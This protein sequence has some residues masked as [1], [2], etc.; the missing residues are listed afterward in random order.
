MQW[1]PLGEGET[2]HDVAHRLC[3]TDL[4]TLAEHAGPVEEPGLLDE[5][6]LETWTWREAR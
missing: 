5:E 3:G 2:L 6:D 4:E 1:G